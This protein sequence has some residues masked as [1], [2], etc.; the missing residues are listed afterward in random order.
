MAVWYSFWSFVIFFPTWYVWTKKNLAT[1]FKNTNR[2][3][4]RKLDKTK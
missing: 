2:L 4:A 1:L 3:F